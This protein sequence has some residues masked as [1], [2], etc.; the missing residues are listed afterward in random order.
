MA[1]TKFDT[2]DVKRRLPAIEEIFLEAQKI[3]RER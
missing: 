2:E 1:E 3:I